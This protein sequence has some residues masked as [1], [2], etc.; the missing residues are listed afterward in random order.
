MSLYSG[1]RGRRLAGVGHVVASL[2]VSMLEVDNLAL[3]VDLGGCIMGLAEVPIG[4]QI[5]G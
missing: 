1:G 4:G 2:L 5:E 3:Q